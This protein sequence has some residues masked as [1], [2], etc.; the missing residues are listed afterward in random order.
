MEVNDKGQSITPTNSVIMFERGCNF[1]IVRRVTLRRSGKFTVDAMYG[2]TADNYN[3]PKG[4]AKKIASFQIDAPPNVDCKIRVIV[5]QDIHGLRTLSS[6]QMVEEVADTTTAVPGAEEQGEEAKVSEGEVVLDDKD[7][8]AKKVKIKKTNLSFTVVRPLDWT[9]TKL[10]REIEVEVDMT[11]NDRIVGQTADARNKLESYIYNMR[12][13][14]MSDI[15]FH[16][17]LTNKFGTR[18]IV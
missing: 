14:I 15:S 13:K 12:N 16:P 1:P 4:L 9:E 10:Q 17:P 2:K 18:L 11:N 3:F 6:A 5:K 7:A 8:T